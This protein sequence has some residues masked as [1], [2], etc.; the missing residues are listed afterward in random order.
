MGVG[1]ESQFD[2]SAS[3]DPDRRVVRYDWD[4]G[5]GTTSRDV[6]AEVRHAYARAGRFRVTVTVRDDEGCGARLVFTGQTALCNGSDT[7][8]ARVRVTVPRP[9]VGVTR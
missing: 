3:S 4:F 1:R 7:A 2:A 8:R 5:D 9:G 6:G